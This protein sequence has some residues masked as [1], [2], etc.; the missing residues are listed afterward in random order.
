V[1]IEVVFPGIGMP[2]MNAVM[3]RWVQ[4]CRSGLLD[5]TLIWGRRHLLH[6]LREFEAFNNE[7]RPHQSIGNARPLR[8]LPPPIVEP[9]DVADLRYGDTD[10][11][12]EASTS[13]GMPSCRVH[14]CEGQETQEHR[15]A[16]TH[17]RC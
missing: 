13:I 9:A 12:A 15:P 3:E 11:W 1:G 10:V 6:A 16:H 7:H 5:R 4:T 8:P 14:R 17:C 2:S